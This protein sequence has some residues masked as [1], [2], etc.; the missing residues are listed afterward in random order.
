MAGGHTL[1]SEAVALESFSA[2]TTIQ[3]CVRTVPFG[4][5]TRVWT[6]ET[7]RG[8][9]EFGGA[10]TEGLHGWAGEEAGSRL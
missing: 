2:V 5:W 7:D 6:G 9:L 8:G 4:R 1:A 10:W 3:A